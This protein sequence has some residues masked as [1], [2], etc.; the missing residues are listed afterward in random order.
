MHA[1]LLDQ[2][3]QTGSLPILRTISHPLPV[4]ASEATKVTGP[5]AECFLCYTWAR[6]KWQRDK[7]HRGN[8]HITFQ[9]A[10]IWS[11][12]NV[13]LMGNA[14]EGSDRWTNDP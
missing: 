9:P 12:D 1:G 3:Y 6:L 2:I 4:L 14:Y 7:P 13:A 11:S 8:Y 5:D 10:D